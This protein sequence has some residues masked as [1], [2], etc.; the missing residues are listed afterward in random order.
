MACDSCVG[1]DG[2]VWAP[3]EGAAPREARES[4]PKNFVEE[5]EGWGTYYCPTCSDGLGAARAKQA[6]LKKRARNAKPATPPIEPPKVEIVE[7]VETLPPESTEHVWWLIGLAAYICAIF[8]VWTVNETVGRWMLLATPIIVLV[9]GSY[10]FA[11]G[12]TPEKRAK[13][14]VVNLQ[15]VGIAVIGLWVLAQCSGGAG[16]GPIDSFFR[17]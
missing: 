17:R 8:G 15:K 12:T 4:W 9:G 3:F 1:K 6:L 11:E 10:Y 5:S 14:F 16:D 7:I 13:H 2:K